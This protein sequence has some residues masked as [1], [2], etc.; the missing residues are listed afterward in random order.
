MT[1][2]PAQRQAIVQRAGGCCEYCRLA[3]TSGTAPFHVDH[4]VPVK[5]G[6]SDDED[7]LCLA[8]YQCNAHKGHDLTGFDPLTGQIE[9]LYHP[10]KQVWTEHFA[11]Q[12]DMRIVG[13][14]PA[15][16]T[17]VRV[18]QMNDEAHIENRQVLAEIDEY[19]CKRELSRR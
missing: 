19:P 7:N 5:Q 11:L 18:L 1:I 3:S 10:R 12:D 9:R 6:G 15:G 16:R 2:S 17:T 4:I 8:C 14:T 13:L